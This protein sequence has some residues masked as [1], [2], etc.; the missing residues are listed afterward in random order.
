MF[1]F[2]RPEHTRQVL[3]SLA[4]NPEAQS[5]DVYV[6]VDGPR[7]DDEREIVQRTCSTVESFASQSP[8]RSLR[9]SYASNNMGLAASVI[10]G[11]SNVLESSPAVIGLEDDTVVSPQF[12][13]FM[14]KALDTY[15]GDN[16][17]WSVSGYRP[18]VRIPNRHLDEVFF[19]S[20]GSSW[21]YGTWADRWRQMDW[22]PE[23]TRR[24]ANDPAFR[25]AFSKA[26]WDLP[27][28]LDMQATG[29]IDSWAIRWCA[30]EVELGSTT[31]Y[32]PVTLVDN[33]GLDG[34]GTHSPRSSKSR[35][36]FQPLPPLRYG[37]PYLSP[38]IA[39][40]FRGS[41]LPLWKLV[42]SRIGRRL[43]RVS[44]NRWFGHSR[45]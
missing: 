24:L 38:R 30:R 36:L 21:G 26:G 10:S 40:V 2:R 15:R 34:S 33:I 39:R 13:S 42:R 9:A 44:K 12:L 4:A 29:A 3:K 25:R 32:P 5:T 35:T 27:L 20:R 37:E 45:H 6:F 8:F 11:I 22:S 43:R 16:L 18:N 19:A 14:N 23:Y 1:A 17:V 31:V 28:M 41:Q 7:R